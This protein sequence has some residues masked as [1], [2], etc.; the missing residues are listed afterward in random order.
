MAATLTDVTD[1][2][3][4]EG[5]L[6][7]NS[8]TNSIKNLIKEVETHQIMSETKFDVLIQQGEQMASMYAQQLKISEG[9]RYDL[10]ET[11]A[12]DGGAAVA[13]TT[14]TGAAIKKEGGGIFSAL[15]GIGT[16]F[17]SIGANLLKFTGLTALFNIL[18]GGLLLPIGGL[19]RILRVG[20]PIGAIVGTLFLFYRAFKDLA[21]DPIMKEFKENWNIAWT[22][23]K[24][25]IKAISDFFADFGLD[26]NYFKGLMGD[27]FG[28]PG[29]GNP[30]GGVLYQAAKGWLKLSMKIFDFA[31][32]P[33][34]YANALYVDTLVPAMNEIKTFFSSIGNRVTYLVKKAGLDIAKFVPELL[35]GITDEEYNKRLKDLEET[36]GSTM[37]DSVEKASRDVYVKRIRKAFE[38][39]KDA[40]LTEAERD[41][42]Q[43]LFDNMFAD[44]MDYDLTRVRLAEAIEE[45]SE[46]QISSQTIIDNSYRSENNQGG[47]AFVNPFTPPTDFYQGMNPGNV[48]VK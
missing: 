29:E 1:R 27:I 33:G 45:L 5:D 23:V 7:R 37:V 36:Y 19:I 15:K 38:D 30:E 18:K 26:K 14:A 9:L 42:A 2:L 20:G 40:S 43:L 3:I 6:I 16:G 4:A 46:G 41:R 28:L 8:G 44:R 31:V 39:S 13:E 24:E 32:N 25:R 34:E 48:G 35:G 10:L 12:E 17:K 22:G 21:D 11:K 47:D